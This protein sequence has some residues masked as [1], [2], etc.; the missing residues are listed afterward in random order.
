MED[1]PSNKGRKEVCTE[2]GA[3]Q[4]AQSRRSVRL[5]SC[6]ALW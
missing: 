2:L 1:H 5:K 3:I 6:G 4:C